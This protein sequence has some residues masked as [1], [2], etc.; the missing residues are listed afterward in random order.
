MAFAPIAGANGGELLFAPRVQAV[1]RPV[2]VA[3]AT[4]AQKTTVVTAC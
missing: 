3:R 1:T 4:S 2:I